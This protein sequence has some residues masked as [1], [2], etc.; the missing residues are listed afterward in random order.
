MDGSSQNVSFE[1]KKLFRSVDDVNRG[2]VDR[3]CGLS[4]TV[5]ARWHPA[6][7]KALAVLQRRFRPLQCCFCLQSARNACSQS[8]GIPS[9]VVPWALPGAG[10]RVPPPWRRF[11]L[12]P[13]VESRRAPCRLPAGY[14]ILRAPPAASSLC[15]GRHIP[16]N[17]GCF[18]DSLLAGE[19]AIKFK[20][21]KIMLNIY[22]K[23]R[24]LLHEAGR[25]YVVFSKRLICKG[26]WYWHNCCYC[27]APPCIFNGG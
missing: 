3:V 12:Q 5:Q 15:L 24:C 1:C 14:L 6:L 26:K 2:P 22:K 18:I 11:S 17:K 20:C 10:P 19:S 16:S 21:I 8:D 25:R 9:N 4:V 7:T 27:S 23:C 13:V